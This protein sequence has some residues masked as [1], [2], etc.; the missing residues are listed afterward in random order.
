[1]NLLK[2][3]S[4][5][6][7]VGF[8]ASSGLMIAALGMV[9]GDIGTSPLYAM[10]LLFSPNSGFRLP[11]SEDNVLGILSLIFWLVTL[12]VTIKY[13]LLILRAD[14][15][16]EGGVIALF[17]LLREKLSKPHSVVVVTLLGL[18]GTSLFLG[19]AVITPAISVLSAVEGLGVASPALSSFIVPIVL[20][21]LVILFSV[22]RFGTSKI[23]LLFGP[24]MLIWF[25]VLAVL[26]LRQI[27]SHPYVLKGINPEYALNFAVHNPAIFLITLSI[28]LL[29]ITGAEALYSDLGHFGRPSIIKAWLLIA[30]PALMLNYFGQGVI[31]LSYSEESDNKQPDSLFF[32]LVPQSLVIPLTIVATIAT[33]IAAQ[34]VISGAFSLASQATKLGFLP[35][36]RVRYPSGTRGQVYVSFINWGLFVAVSVVVLIFTSSAR[37][38]DAYG[39]SVVACMLI[40]TLL[41]FTLV[42]AK[43]RPLWL[44][45]SGGAIFLTVD[46]LLLISCLPK[47]FKG[48]W[49]A[50]LIAGSVFASL[51]IWH[52]GVTFVVSQRAIRE[53]S[54]AKF[55]KYINVERIRRIPT[56]A[57]YLHPDNISV[58][59]SMR[60]TVE[61]F[62][63]LHSHAIL[64]SVVIAD[65]P[66]VDLKE[67]VTIDDLSYVD[68]G[69]WF[70]QMTYGF[71]DRVDIPSHLQYAVDKFPQLL[72]EAV[73]DEATYYVSKFE[74]GY[75]KVPHLPGILGRYFKF[76]K[77]MAADPIKFYKLPLDR[78]VTM[79]S[80]IT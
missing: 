23:G 63:L 41:F 79:T 66:H 64:V 80:H 2:E 74:I 61:R 1:M 44:V 40:D 5:S 29:S 48:G 70:V 62:G 22:Q 68:D 19:D 37:L 30:F 42:R 46:I 32:A 54:L 26:G 12:I 31:L 27:I 33:I 17:T 8:F 11:V 43:G 34:A 67:S 76:M 59:L 72:D 77:N 39:I 73:L 58:P 51:W 14:N 21:I 55:I 16:G 15:Q 56:T 36:I 25:T 71:N 10:S 3:K 52:V 18:A 24:A 49:V 50:L 28:A 20:I 35:R 45:L 69:I 53:G 7:R 6:S 57:V 9:F 75:A 47:I 78:T 65:V 4:K 60:S 38:A 13:A